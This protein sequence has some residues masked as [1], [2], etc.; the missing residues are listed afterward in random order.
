M[1]G[2]LPHTKTQEFEVTTLRVEQFANLLGAD[3]EN[4]Q[5]NKFV[6]QML[7][8]AFESAVLADLSSEGSMS[9][10]VAHESESL[11]P[12]NNGPM[13]I[14]ANVAQKGIKRTIIY[15]HRQGE[16]IIGEGKDII[17]MVPLKGERNPPEPSSETYVFHGASYT[18]TREDVN[19]FMDIAEDYN[20]A[21][22]DEGYT[23]QTMF[24]RPIV[25]GMLGLPRE[26]YDSMKILRGNGTDGSL[27]SLTV[28]FK[29]PVYPKEP[30]YKYHDTITPHFSEVT[31]EVTGE[32]GIKTYDMAVRNQKNVDVMHVSFTLTTCESCL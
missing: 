11:L 23:A 10:Y 21:H 18:P 9:I 22:R 17:L 14:E 4:P 13:I 15:A 16:I 30:Q 25:H 3:P 1:F 28:A 32:N 8:L 19:V 5:D 20:L 24:K 6:R 26:I 31:G 27:S 2:Q 12:V 7:P 29:E